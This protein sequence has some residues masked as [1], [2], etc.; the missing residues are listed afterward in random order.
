[1]RE[2]PVPGKITVPLTSTFRLAFLMLKTRSRFAQDTS[3]PQYLAFQ[4]QRA[5]LDMQCLQAK[6]AVFAPASASFNTLVIRSSANLIR[7]I[8]H[9]SSRIRLKSCVKKNL[10]VTSTWIF[11]SVSV[12]LLTQHPYKRAHSHF[13]YLG[14]KHRI[15][16]IFLI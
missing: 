7:L 5:A 11:R 16:C 13:R 9:P 8:V 4:L 2:S 10:G 14:I 15:K 12:M 3:K 6:S 1:M